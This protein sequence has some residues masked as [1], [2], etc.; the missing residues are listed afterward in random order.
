MG[1]PESLVRYSVAQ[2]KRNFL[3][4][5]GQDT[6]EQKGRAAIAQAIANTGGTLAGETSF[7]LSQTGVINAIPG[8]ASQSRSSGADAIFIHSGVEHGLWQR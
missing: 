8:I 5:N 6:A 2:G 1:I 4:V 3:I 7:E